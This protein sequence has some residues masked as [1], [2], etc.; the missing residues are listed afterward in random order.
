MV[1]R[2]LNIC[3]LCLGNAVETPFADSSNPTGYWEHVGFYSINEKL[4][5]HLGGT[6]ENPPVLSPGWE[7]DLSIGPFYDETR[8]AIERSFAGRDNWGWKLPRCLATMAFWR[9][10]VPDLRIVICV[11]NPLDYSASI[12]ASH[13][14]ARRHALRMW[15]Y[16]NVTALTQTTPSE[17]FV[18]FYEDYFPDYRAALYP[19]LNFAGLPRPADDSDAAKQIEAFHDAGLNHHKSTL[20]D[21]MAD[22][23]ASDLTKQLYKELVTGPPDASHLPVLESA[24]LILPDLLEHVRADGAEYERA[25]ALKNFRKIEIHRNELVYE[26]AL[27][28]MEVEHARAEAKRTRETEIESIRQSHAGEVAFLNHRIDSLQNRLDQANAVLNSRI[29]RLAESARSLMNRRSN[30][31]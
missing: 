30:N 31:G 6:F 23:T 26:V 7:L 1:A 24:A 25:N 3:G 9:R 21:V 15:D 19:L 10:A 16:Y 2:M 13:E 4:L 29:H 28:K 27:Q 17:R 22:Q 18:T 5:A 20:D 14:V 12:N 11:R 8:D